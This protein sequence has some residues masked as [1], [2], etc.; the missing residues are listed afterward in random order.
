MKHD[1]CFFF[2]QNV[3][4]YVLERAHTFHNRRNIDWPEANET[5]FIT[6]MLNAKHER[7]VCRIESAIYKIEITGVMDSVTIFLFCNLSDKLWVWEVLQLYFGI[8]IKMVHFKFMFT[9]FKSAFKFTTICWG[10]YSALY[11]PRI[12]I[13]VRIKRCSLKLF[14][15]LS[16][17]IEDDYR[18]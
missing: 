14:D 12:R 9:T 7:S 16:S 18:F 13:S 11:V 10:G 1:I 3:D 4:I 17:S 15:R 8:A 5:N 2:A 6:T